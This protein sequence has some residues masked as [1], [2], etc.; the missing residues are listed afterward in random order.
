M[1]KKPK[2]PFDSNRPAKLICDATTAGQQLPEFREDGKCR[3]E[4]KRVIKGS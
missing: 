1:S 4:E 3:M 2:K